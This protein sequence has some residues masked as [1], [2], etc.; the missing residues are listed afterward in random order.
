MS[1]ESKTGGNKAEAAG[2]GEG[3]GKGRRVCVTGAT[4]YLGSH[5]V[6]QLLEQGY[7]VRA[8]VRDP[9]N[10]ENVGH[11]RSLVEAPAHALELVRGD[12]MQPDGLD[13]PLADCELV[14]HMA[15]P[16]RLFAKDPQRDIVD[17][18]VKGT[19]HV[20]AAVARVGTVR[21]V[22]LTS[23]VGA[24]AGYDKPPSYVFTEADWNETADLTVTPY[25]LS[26]TLAERAAWDFHRA[27]PQGSRFELV[28]LNPVF[29][30]G[31][32]LKKAHV[33]SSPNTLRDLL[34][35]KMPACPRF[36]L[37]IVDVRDV[38]LA[39]LRALELP[40]VS[41]RYLLHSRGLWMREMAKIIAPR[42]PDYPVPTWPLPDVA[43]YAASFFDKRLTVALLRKQLGWAPVIDNS[44]S[45]RELGLEYRSIEETLVDTCQSFIDLGMARPKR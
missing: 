42:F 20:L 4:G 9:D 27:Q 31:P 35:R 28:A 13:A 33:R 7:R 1:D 23:S 11:L 38:A 3:S 22:V 21:R 16:V 43:V 34:I 39:H 17:V 14:C 12:V 37:S 18:A 24:V 40:E 6:R 25:L 5:V 19:E 8:M 29:V 26:K 36:H 30:M 45:R 10:E 32:L 41:G 44:R 15:S 2:S